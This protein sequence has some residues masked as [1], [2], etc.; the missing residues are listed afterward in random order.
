MSATYS[1]GCS[2]HKLSLQIGQTNTPVYTGDVEVMDLFVT[3]LA[4][5]RDCNGDHSTTL[6][7]FDDN[8]DEFYTD[9][10]RDIEGKAK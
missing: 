7:Y 8:W 5:H 1:I 10:W 4:K 2:K 9:G 3:L 6:V